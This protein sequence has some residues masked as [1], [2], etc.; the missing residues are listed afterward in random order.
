MVSMRFDLPAHLPADL[1][2]RRIFFGYLDGSETRG[3]RPAEWDQRGKLG[4]SA[5]RERGK[6]GIRTREVGITPPGP[7]AAKWDARP[8]RGI[9]AGGR[10]HRAR[11]AGRSAGVPRQSWDGTHGSWDRRAGNWD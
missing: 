5:G 3:R 7:R 6:V 11:A 4:W 8:R 1:P 2:A 9:N 10:D